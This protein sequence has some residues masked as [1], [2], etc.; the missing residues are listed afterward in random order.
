MPVVIVN[1]ELITELKSISRRV[2]V[3]PRD[4]FTGSV[5]ELGLIFNKQEI[6]SLMIFILNEF[7][8]RQ[9]M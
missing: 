5:S 8:F 3:L 2:F 9:H 7:F 4:V 1:M 6:F